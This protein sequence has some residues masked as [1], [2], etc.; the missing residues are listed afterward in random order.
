MFLTEEGQIHSSEP[1]TYQV[2]KKNKKRKRSKLRKAIKI[3]FTIIL[4]LLLL[5]LIAGGFVAYKIYEIAKDVKL[6][7]NDLAIKYEN[8]VIKDITGNTL[9]VLNGDENRVSISLEN[10]TQYLPKAFISIEDERFYTHKGVDIKRTLGATYTYLKNKGNS[11]FGGSTITQ[12]LVKNLT[13]EKEDTWQ[14]KVREMTRAYYVEQEM[15]KEEILELYLNLIFLGDT[16][17]GVQQGSKYYFNKDAQD[18]SLAE[19]A[20][21]AGINHSPNSYNPFIKDNE[22]VLQNIKTR[23]IIVLNKMNELGNINSQ[24]EYEQAITEVQQGLK[25]EQGA[26]PE[27]LLSYH[28]DATINQ[29]INQ[30]QRKYYWTYEQ[31]RLYLFSGGFTIYTTQ[32]PAMQAVMQEEFNKEKYRTTA[33]DEFGN[34]QNSQAA[35][36]LIDHKTGHVLAICSGFDEK[37]EPFGFNRATEAKKQTGSSMK[38]IAVLAPA[39]DRGIITAATIFDDNLTSFNNGTYEPKNYGYKYRGLISV[40]DAIAYSQNIPMVKAMCLLT[41]E[42]SIEFLKSVG[43]TS[44]DEERDNVLPLALGGLTWGITPLQMAGAYATIAN[45]GVY[46][47]PTF[48]TKVIDLDGNIVLEPDQKKTQAMSEATAFVVKE[49][50]TQPVKTGTSTTCAIE[51]MDV[52]AKTG[53]TNNDYDRWLCGFTPYYTATVWYGY[54]NNASVTGWTLNPASQ[55]WTGVMSQIHNGLESKTFYETKPEKVVEVETCK[56]SGFLATSTC[57]SNKTTY[58]EYFVQGTEPIQTCPYHSS[59]KVCLESGLLANENCTKTKRVYGKGEYINGNGLWKTQ[60]T[61][62]KPKNVPTARCTIH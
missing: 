20:F 12:Q 28:T 37:T 15:S 33:I 31:A 42:K 58:T 47:E 16:V 32:D 35:M 13:Q 27:T 18:L 10:M 44:L 62:Y 3:F 11:S 23:T 7:K 45:D 53:T 59:A 56:K 5:I 52:A 43:I 41:P 50:L 29:I 17:Y 51:G 55:I 25:F 46:I 8:S 14:R 30:L 4:I 39:I 22:K 57:R 9:A 40:R 60:S 2:V 19:C 61:Y 38:T 49:I 1:Q 21:L 26:F 48:Y 24:Q 54:D 36:V 6:D 34:L